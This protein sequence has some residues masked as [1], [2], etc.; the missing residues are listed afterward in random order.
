MILKM[1]KLAPY[2]SGYKKLNENASYS[3]HIDVMEKIAQ[4]TNHMIDKGMNIETIT[5]YGIRR[6]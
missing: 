3:Q 2:G 4:L 6:W 5:Y 1:V